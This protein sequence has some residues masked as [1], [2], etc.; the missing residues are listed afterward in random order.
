MKKTIRFYFDF[1]SPYSYLA[2]TQLPALAEKY[3][4]SIALCPLNI[5]T[6]MGK[7]GNRPTSIECKPKGKY[8]M[9]DV[10]RWAAQ[11]KVPVQ[12]NPHIRSMDATL[13]ATG[14]YA[15]AAHGVEKLYCKAVFNAVWAEANPI[16]KTEDLGLILGNAAVAQSAG[17]TAGA[18]QQ[19]ADQLA[20]GLQSHAH[21]IFADLE[22]AKSAHEA[23]Q[24]QASLDGV[25]G[26]PSFVV[27]GKLFFGND[28]L[29]F[30][31]RELAK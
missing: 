31:E 20:G 6:L 16:A 1:L 5:I 23:M 10:G 29:H 11:Y 8:A 19:L 21:E 2:S 27:D 17:L 12:L 7:V 28:R 13:L 3:D 18:E 14:A 30:L 25:F 9:Q 22:N 15:A 26:A 24:E 4:A